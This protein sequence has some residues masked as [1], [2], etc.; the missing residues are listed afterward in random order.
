MPAIDELQ[1]GEMSADIKPK[2]ST[3]VLASWRSW[4]KSN[5]A[6]PVRDILQRQIPINRPQLARETSS[7][8]WQIVKAAKKTVQPSNADV[9]TQA[10]DLALDDLRRYIQSETRAL[11]D[12]QSD[13][14]RKR[15]V[16]W[17]KVTTGTQQFALTF[18]QFLGAYSGVVSIV[19]E[20]D[21]NYG[22]AATATLSLLYAT[23]KMKA[24]DEE[25][26]TATMQQITDQLPNVDIYQHIYADPQLG[27]MLANVY[28]QIM[29][30]AR[31]AIEYAQGHGHRRLFKSMR[32]P[33]KFMGI[34]QEMR[35]SFTNIKVRCEA[36]LASRVAELDRRNME[37][38]KEL[39]A[40]KVQLQESARREDN[41]AVVHLRKSLGLEARQ[42]SGTRLEQVKSHR[43]ILRALF[44]RFDGEVERLDLDKLATF[45]KYKEW[46][47]AES[48]SIL[49]L[50]GR[51]AYGYYQFGSYSWLSEAACEFI[52]SIMGQPDTRD[53]IAYCLPQ[54]EVLPEKWLAAITG[55]F[56]ELHPSVV[57]RGS[58][59]RN[60]DL[61]ISR[62][63]DH[64]ARLTTHDTNATPDSRLRGDRL[65]SIAAAL[66]RIIN[67]IPGTTYIVIDSADQ[68]DK[69]ARGALLETLVQVASQTENTVKIL[70]LSRQQFWDFGDKLR[71]LE[72]CHIVQLR[73]DQGEL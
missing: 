53:N 55:Q 11:R 67:R 38:L 41:N 24:D 34:D 66:I 7:E 32:R 8:L 13:L 51:N 20:I 40:L 52:E 57:R 16:G 62:S 43:H 68:C 17:K 63:I 25:A 31:E 12:A 6:T 72:S 18:G 29:R 26:I 54:D 70:L 69:T 71:E 48:S 33:G 30:F 58:D 37:L 56:L 60:I 10:G 28:V 27:E 23:V 65:K 9:L 21:S 59:L 14:S 61:D 3:S 42:P 44:G 35:A 22:G 49:A 64:S 4:Y 46:R 39:A 36:L 50:Q 45:A 2:E 1:K 19:K 47:D 15:H 5:D 73:I